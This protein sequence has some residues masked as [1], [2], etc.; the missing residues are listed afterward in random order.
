MWWKRKRLVRV[1]LVGDEPSIEGIYNG[2]VDGHYRIDTPSVIEA[3]DRSHSLDG[4]VLIP[5]HKV[6][7]I[8]VLVDGPTR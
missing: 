1:H 4:W 2:R 7:F 3:S 6:A 8:Q 5:S